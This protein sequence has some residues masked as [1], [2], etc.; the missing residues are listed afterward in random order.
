MHPPFRSTL[1][2]SCSHNNNNSDRPLLARTLASS[3]L[4]TCNILTHAFLLD[5]K[6]SKKVPYHR[7]K[8][9]FCLHV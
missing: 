8:Y 6:S 9:D 2:Y 4:T 7:Q 3:L 1:D 5:V